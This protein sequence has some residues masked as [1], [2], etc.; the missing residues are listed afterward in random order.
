LL[1]LLLLAASQRADWY[2]GTGRVA[3]SFCR[4]VCLSVCLSVTTV[5]SRKTADSIEMPFAA[6]R[7]SEPKDPFIRLGSRCLHGKKRNFWGQIERRYVTVQGEC[8]PAMRRFPNYVGISCYHSNYFVRLPVQIPRRKRCKEM[9]QAVS[10]TSPHISLTSSLWLRRYC[11]GVGDLDVT[12]QHFA[13]TAIS[14]PTGQCYY[15]VGA[16]YD[17]VLI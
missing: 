14:S 12:I 8:A 11:T 17:E 15:S 6:E 13:Q 16:L 2:T 3:S 5:N 1:L 4:S 7:S 9:A 10:V